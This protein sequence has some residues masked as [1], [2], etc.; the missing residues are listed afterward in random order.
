MY[1]IL[2]THVLKQHCNHKYKNNAFH[3]LLVNLFIVEGNLHALISNSVRKSVWHGPIGREQRTRVSI[4][5]AGSN[6]RCRR[7]RDCGAGLRYRPA[8]PE[9]QTPRPTSRPPAEQTRRPY[10]PTV[11]H[12]P[13]HF[14]IGEVETI[15]SLQL[16]LLIVQTGIWIPFIFGQFGFRFTF[17]IC[18]IRNSFII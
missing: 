18:L 2:C 10:S 17:R 11:H 6:K 5:A 8:L 12:L 15:G 16:D 13:L 3:F 7:S 4:G 14:L 1:I 9:R